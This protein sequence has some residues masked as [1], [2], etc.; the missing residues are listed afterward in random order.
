MATH[1]S[2]ERQSVG[3]ACRCDRYALLRSA[4]VASHLG[5][6]LCWQVRRLLA[7]GADA[8]VVN[9]AGRNAVAIAHEH[10]GSAEWLLPQLDE[11]DRCNWQRQQDAASPIAGKRHTGKHAPT[12]HVGR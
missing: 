5:L 8:T 10:R 9:G 4:T 7:H 1:H 11:A 6:A 3:M 12:R 2:I